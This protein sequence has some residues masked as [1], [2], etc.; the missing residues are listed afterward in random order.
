MLVSKFQRWSESLNN[1]IAIENVVMETNLV[2]NFAVCCTAALTLD[3][4]DEGYLSKQESDVRIRR[5]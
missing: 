4:S 3:V 5:P 1:S 2:T